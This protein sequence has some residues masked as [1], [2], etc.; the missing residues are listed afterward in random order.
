MSRQQVPAALALKEDDVQKMLVAQCHMGTVNCV[1]G[2]QTYTWKRRADG[3]FLIN[4]GKTWE[5]LVLAAR[6]I[7]AI[8]NPQ[9]VVVVS[10]RPY[11][12]R[13]ILKFAQY[14]GVQAI[15]G[16][17]TPG[18]F[19]NQIQQKFVEPRLIIITDPRIDFQPLKESSYCNVPVIAFC[20]TDSAMRYVD[21]AI[22]CNNKSKH[23]IGLLYWLLAREV[24]Y[25]RGSLPRTEPWSVM[26]DLFFF[27]EPTEEDAKD[28]DGHAAQDGPWDGVTPHPVTDDGTLENWNGPGGASAVSGG[29]WGSAT[30]SDAA[31][32]TPGG[33]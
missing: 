15:A 9:D 11:A 32:I 7:A 22:P 18:T 4:L 28:E 33:P 25:L 6:V 3:V 12:Q 26:P 16:R 24:L 30:V 20:D 1:T 5:K 19:T 14:T 8:E 31:A 29:E 10:A 27:R 21:I 2:M 17:F 13:A 23:S